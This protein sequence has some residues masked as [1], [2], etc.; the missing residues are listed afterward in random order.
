MA[1]HAIIADR[2]VSVEQYLSSSYEH[3][4]E[5]IDGELKEK[6]MPTPLHAF[7]QGLLC[8]WF[9]NHTREWGVLALPEART[10]VRPR[11]FRLPDVSIARVGTR[12]ERTLDAPSLI[13][14]EVLS[15]DD[16]FSELLHRAS[17]L[18]RMGVENI[19]LLDPDD[20]TAYRYTDG[21]WRTAAALEVP[22][23]PIHLAIGWLWS[24]V[25]L[26]F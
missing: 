10:Q 2:T 12:F 21:D 9:L 18:S 8:Q 23:S 4:M 20:R 22:E 24:E 15:A 6:P 11:N 7:V 17:D 13:A 5:F 3:D 16:T 19:W 25:A 1:A 14:I 26:H